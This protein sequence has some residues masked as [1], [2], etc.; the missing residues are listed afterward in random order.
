MSGNDMPLTVAHGIKPV[1]IENTTNHLPVNI[2]VAAKSRSKTK[3][4]ITVKT[5]PGAYVTIAAVDEGILQVKN[6][7]T[8]DPYQLFLSERSACYKQL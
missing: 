4:T 8:P 7:E 2:Y 5:Q 6:Y 1:L 3:Q